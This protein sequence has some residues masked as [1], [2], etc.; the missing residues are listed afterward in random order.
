MATQWTLW[1]KGDTICK[2]CLNSISG[3]P[4]PNCTEPRHLKCYNKNVEGIRQ[5]RKQAQVEAFI[6][7]SET[8][9]PKCVLC[10]FSNIIA[11]Q[12]DHIKGDGAAFRRE[13]PFQ[14]GKSLA[15]WLR[16]RNWPKGYRVLCANCQQIERERIGNNG[17]HKLCQ[18][19]STQITL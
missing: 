4:R 9:P 8:I 11:L 18:T 14:S 17:A 13:H 19:T 16:K 5:N 12:L 1:N 10:G 2:V 6:Q 15:L 3:K 7:Y